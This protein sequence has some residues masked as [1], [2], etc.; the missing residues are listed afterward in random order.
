MKALTLATLLALPASCAAD[1]Y[2]PM[3]PPYV[4]W[5]QDGE[6]RACIVTD[7]FAEGTVQPADILNEYMEKLTGAK[8]PVVEEP[9]GDAPTVYLGPQSGLARLKEKPDLGPEGFIIA[10]EGKSLIISGQNRLSTLYG[11]CA[12]LEECLGVRWFW[13]D[14]TG[15]HVPRTD[16]LRIGQVRRVQNPDFRYRWIGRSD[17]ALANRMNVGTGQPDEFR[18]KWFVHTFLRLVPPEKYWADHPEYYAM[19]GGARQ[20]PTDRTRR[21][22]LCTSNPEVAQAVA[23][24]IDEIMAN[25][26]GFDM[27]SVDPEDGQSFCQCENCRALDEPG[28]P[29]ARKNS[30]RLALFYNHVAELV[31]KK[32]PDLLLKSIAY[33]SYVAP[34]ADPDIKMHD[35]VVIQF[36]R[37]EGHDHPLFD[38][39]NPKNREFNEQYQ[40]WRKITRNIIFYE[41]YWKVSWL[42]LPWPIM[43][44][45]REEIP[46]L[47]D[48]GLMGI[49]TQYTSNFATHG[50]GYYVAAKLLWDA[51]IDVDALVQDFYQKAFAEAESPMR[52]YYERL[53]RAV[54]E[55]G[56]HLAGQRPYAEVVRLFTPDVMGDL[57]AAMAR[58][59]AAVKDEKAKARVELVAKGLV[60]TRMVVDYLS[61]IAQV[62]AKA[63]Q[64][65][66]RGGASK[67]LQE[68]ARQ[69]A[70]DKAEAIRAY[71]SDNANRM[72]VAGLN[73]Y[74]EG[75]LKPE[76]VMGAWRDR[77]LAEGVALT[78][79]TWLKGHPQRFSQSLPPQFD[80]WVYGNDLDFV[81][82]KPEHTILVKRG[83]GEEV[84]LGH[85][86][87]PER[88]GDRRNRAYI[89]SGLTPDHLA[90]GKLQL[91][92]TNDPGGPYASRFFAFYVMP[93]LPELDG[94]VATKKIETDLEWVRARSLGF[95]EYGYDG[96]RS[97]DHDRTPVSVQVLGAPEEG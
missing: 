75:M 57:E 11:V 28:A 53:E 4:T 88:P 95:L 42:H 18:T 27:I 30:R 6:A 56:V 44:T 12:F 35:N 33:H 32:H 74:I 10:S 24:T 78:K 47:R 72:A 52:E 91:V 61:T 26:P 21:V 97:D 41:Y 23:E 31:A 29:Y 1:L 82:G 69:L 45:L 20:D 38:T 51:D 92:V 43:H 96:L 9:Q 48:Q 81:E 87:T 22:Q 65:R 54:I 80:L 71:L 64:V 46:Y 62:R 89:L 94:D 14:E 77:A 66:W 55:S 93:R 83:D 67:D 60:Y 2:E 40:G 58:A 34:P 70:G 50:L 17:W 59:R 15:E 7:E 36:C 13:A 5:V 37:F 84:V 86:A 63:P 76:Q 73:G 85:V 16:T 3:K 39:T 19:R 68:E 8:L 90:D 79:E 25:D 49:A